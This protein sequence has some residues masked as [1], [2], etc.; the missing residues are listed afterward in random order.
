[1]KLFIIIS[2]LIFDVKGDD[3]FFDGVKENEVTEYEIREDAEIGYEF[4]CTTLK[5]P[6]YLSDVT[7]PFNIKWKIQNKNF[8]FILDGKLDF[9]IIEVYRFQIVAT[10][11]DSRESHVATIRII[12]LKV[13]K[14]P[15]YFHPY[16]I[17]IKLPE[18]ELNDKFLTLEASDQD[19]TDFLKSH[20]ENKE[21]LDEKFDLNQN[22][23]YDNDYPKIII[24]LINKEPLDYE[25]KTSYR[26]EVIVKDN[27]KNKLKGNVFSERAIIHIDV[28]DIDD[29][30]PTF[31]RD[32]GVKRIKEHYKG[33]VTEVYAI[34]GDRGVNNPIEYSLEN[35][36]YFGIKKSNLNGILFVEDDIDR[37]NE[38]I[39]NN[40]ILTFNIKANEY[41]KNNTPVSNRTTTS[42]CTII[43]E[44]INDNSPIFDKSHYNATVLENT[45]IGMPVT[46][47][48][49]FL[50]KVSDIDE[51]ENARYELY[52]EN[53]EEIFLITP[54]K[55]INEVT[56]AIRVN[57]SKELD[58]E[59]EDLEPKQFNFTIIARET[60]KEN[61]TESTA[62]ITVF[63]ED[64]NDNFPQFDHI[65]QANIYENASIGDF[66][67]HIKATD[68]DSGYYGTKG[69]R[70]KLMPSHISSSLDINETS[71]YITVAE[72]NTFDREKVEDYYLTIEARDENGTGNAN[73]TQLHLYILDV[74]DNEPTFPYDN[75]RAHLMENSQNFADTLRLEAT[76][77]DKE[78]TDNS[79]IR[80]TIVDGDLK[81]Q[82]HID[83]ENGI[84]TPKSPIDFEDNEPA[85]DKDCI[86]ICTKTYNLT[87]MAYDLGIPRQS[88]EVSVYIT[89]MDEN[90][91][92]PE[93]KETRLTA[94]INETSDGGTNVA[95]VHATDKDLSPM[96]SNVSFS[97]IE[98][99]NNNFIIGRTTGNIIIAHNAYLNITDDKSKLSYELKIEATDAMMKKRDNHVCII[100]INVSDINDVPPKFKNVPTTG[101]KILENSKN[102]KIGDFEAIDPDE[103]KKLEYSI[104]YNESEALQPDMIT[105][106]DKEKY[107]YSNL[108]TINEKSEVWIINPADREEMK[109][110]DLTIKV[111]DINGE[112]NIPQEDK[113]HFRIIILD[114]NDNDP[115]FVNNNTREGYISK[116]SENR[117][118]IML[119]SILA[120]DIDENNTITYSLRE[121]SDYFYL[122]NN[123]GELKIIKEVDYEEK[124]WMNF[125]VFAIDNGVPSRNSSALVSIEILDENDNTPQFVGEPYKAKIK[126]HEP[127]GTF[128]IQINATD[129]DS[130][131]K[132]LVYFKL[133]DMH[134][135]DYHF[136]M[137]NKTGII[138]V[139][140]D[141]DREIKEEY[142][143]NIQAYDNPFDRFDQNINHTQ[144]IIT[145]IDINDNKPEIIP[146][147]KCWRIPETSPIKEI[148]GTIR[149][150]DKDKE[151]TP[152]AEIEFF[153]ID[154]SGY[155]DIKL[156]GTLF[157]NSSLENLHQEFNIEIMAKD[158]GEPPLNS[159]EKFCI[160]IYDMN[161][162]KP[163]F[164]NPDPK[165][166]PPRKYVPENS[167]DIPFQPTVIYKV[168]AE[169]LDKDK[170][171]NGKITYEIIQDDPDTKEYTQT[172][173][174]DENGLI[175]V[176]RKLRKDVKSSYEIIVQACDN[177][178]P[179]NCAE[180]KAIIHV[181][182]ISEIDTKPKFEKR[183]IEV[184]FTEHSTVGLEKVT[185]PEA[186]SILEN[187][188]TICYYIVGGDTKIF[189]LDKNERI[190]TILQELD[191]EVIPFHSIIVQA[192]IDCSVD[193]LAKINKFD[194][195]Y[196]DLINITIRV[197]DINDN[198]PKFIRPEFQ[199]IQDKSVFTGGVKATDR[200]GKH[201]LSVIAIDADEGE[202]A[203]VTYQLIG[204]ITIKKGENLAG[205]ND[206]FH[207]N[208]TTGQILLAFQP[209]SEMKGHFNFTVMAKDKDNLNDTA[210]VLIYLMRE[211]Q[212]I[213]IMF[214]KNINK[215]TQEDQMTLKNILQ[216]S[217]N[218]IVNIDDIMPYSGNDARYNGFTEVLIHFVNPTLNEVIE[219]NEAINIM[220][221]YY[222]E[223][224]EKIETTVGA[225]HVHKHKEE[226]NKNK[227]F[228][229]NKNSYILFATI[230]TLTL[231]IFLVLI[232]YFIRISSYKRLL[233][234]ATA[235]AYNDP[236]DYE[237]RKTS[238]TIV[239][240]TNLHAMQ[241]SNP[242]WNQDDNIKN[243][244]SEE[245]ESDN[246]SQNSLDI[247]EV[248]SIT[249]EKQG[250]DNPV[251]IA[252]NDDD[253]NYSSQ[254]QLD[255]IQSRTIYNQENFNENEKMNNTN[256]MDL[257]KAVNND[258]RRRNS[259]NDFDTNMTIPSSFQNGD[260]Y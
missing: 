227:S 8:C 142:R 105:K 41:Y 206:F 144:V 252:D 52:L 15:P 24:N 201:I 99:G 243:C 162:H 13:N 16:N 210:Y 226:T 31:I 258:W 143:I 88:S 69:I 23:F 259:N 257:L 102:N 56:F 39:I 179:Q 138:T 161:T 133:S 73:T 253:K 130:E 187:N 136:Q 254:Q 50:P 109:T 213:K 231:C 59:R 232:V 238:T 218:F 184:N 48:A 114:E 65:L 198:A 86:T 247:N 125:S 171:T 11:I 152:N 135:D 204:D 64:V 182:I 155:F 185:I 193:T 132:G 37:E 44:D 80:Y 70:Y 28:E 178:I 168:I 255:G 129:K 211:D 212:Q 216:S 241:G 2:L 83:S 242:I 225:I 234:A 96:Y 160:D 180:E 195:K 47:T 215:F 107:N 214:S 256:K 140:K 121:K 181:F 145:L 116:V 221:R 158:K 91:N 205:I 174:I 4:L 251:F 197:L 112:I 36:S 46:F 26:I 72:N 189:H 54:T 175:Y 124:Q 5:K 93:F 43:I 176:N 209:T 123:S 117:K 97:I 240:N 62:N 32:C 151:G 78:G 81:K 35:K 137:E 7:R 233:K 34:D 150:T 113:M 115:F 220:D 131:D 95:Q 127:K 166:P 203:I 87:V 60:T 22:I 61:P 199:I 244:F 196:L 223:I 170:T 106:V 177:G 118:D 141:L 84:I 219:A 51:G 139:L 250:K 237:M 6:A 153:M 163:R 17:T 20:I 45:Q 30:N 192:Y 27:Q 76:D 164:V 148:I 68:I 194:E 77:K 53:H 103:T 3:S 10:E 146:N 229:E 202:N 9:S 111:V 75:Y 246:E 128:V 157:V 74:N 156:D 236:N 188:N 228:W 159:T 217:T 248:E 183:Q 82:F 230:A 40:P 110:I 122:N 98:G 169:D 134:S 108:F 104:L 190:L 67:A 147:D 89:L 29:Q 222:R 249:D 165:N 18:E 66:V 167:D 21:E 94:N 154:T 33:S 101:Y 85:V 63:L 173:K 58:Y 1:M 186:T 224:S 92:E 55:G 120:K 79:K 149:A 19:K 14:Y 100:K 57:N 191:R 239:P 126:E 172:F 25:S 208:K 90:D 38:I 235:K 71:G 260:L 200:K 12:I 207:L 119:F 49:E 42:T 245:P